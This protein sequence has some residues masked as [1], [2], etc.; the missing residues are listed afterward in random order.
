M[1]LAPPANPDEYLMRYGQCHGNPEPG[2][3]ADSPKLANLNGID[4][5]DQSQPDEKDS[6]QRRMKPL[7]LKDHLNLRHAKL[8]QH[9]ASELAIHGR[10]TPTLRITGSRILGDLV[11][12]LVRFT[13]KF[14]YDVPL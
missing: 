5:S 13:D 7:L 11:E 12:P 1:K 3:G 10:G 8:F 14:L 4:A 2:R 6:K 9:D